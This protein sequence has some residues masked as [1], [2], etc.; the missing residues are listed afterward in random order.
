MPAATMQNIAWVRGYVTYV[1]SHRGIAISIITITST[2]PSH[3]HTTIPPYH[4]PFYHPIYHH[5]HHRSLALLLSGSL[6]LS[7]YL[8]A[9]M[10]WLLPQSSMAQMLT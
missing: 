5:H 4:L 8:N 10:R 6:A 7:L 1:T 9:S 3:T 2:I